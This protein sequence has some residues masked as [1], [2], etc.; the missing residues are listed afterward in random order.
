MTVCTSKTLKKLAKAKKR[1]SG[2]G[3]LLSSNE[4]DSDN[5][6][7]LMTPETVVLNPASLAKMSSVFTF[8]L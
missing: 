2:E 4:N 6:I 1:W 3:S 5:P 8:E 7:N